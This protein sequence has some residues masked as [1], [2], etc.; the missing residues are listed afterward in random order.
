M[1]EVVKCRKI[2]Y[3]P[4]L[5]EREQH[6]LI[7]CHTEEE[8]SLFSVAFID[9]QTGAENVYIKVDIKFSELLK[10]DKVAII[11]TELTIIRGIL[12]LL[13]LLS[14]TLLLIFRGGPLGFLLHQPFPSLEWLFPLD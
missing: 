11:C 5:K 2:T 14:C 13:L 6:A 4:Q 8:F 3:E 12:S 9:E 1:A 10:I 7:G